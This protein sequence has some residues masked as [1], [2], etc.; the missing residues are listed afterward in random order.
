MKQSRWIWYP[1]DFE[2]YHSLRLHCRREERG[3]CWPAFWHLDD[4]N[5]NV[6]FRKKAVLD[7]NETVTV[8]GH[9]MGYLQADGKKHPYNTPVELVPGE[10]TLEVAAAKP[11]GL[12]AVFIK[13]DVF[14]GTEGWE[15]DDMTGNWLPAGYNDMYPLPED[16][17]E[18][19][20][21]SYEEVGPVS[22][23]RKN[24]GVLF[25]FGRE[26]FA[27]LRFRNASFSEPVP[28]FY[29]ESEAEAL[30]TEWS[31]IRD[32]IPAGMDSCKMKSRAFRYIFV[33]GTKDELEISADYEYLPL[34]PRGNFRSSDEKL[35]RIW[36]T[37]AY[38]F[39]LNC[40]EFF[41]DGIKRDRWVWSGDA[42]QSFL[43]NDYLFFDPGITKRT[44]IA[45][46]GKDPVRQHINTILD[47]SFYW[48]L[49][50]HNYYYKTGDLEFLRFIWPK[51]VTLMDFCLSRRDAEGFVTGM[52]GD[53]VFIDWAEIDKTGA[54]AA[55]QILFYKSLQTMAVCA[56]VLGSNGLQYQNIA[57]ELYQK[58]NRFFWNPRLHA[59]IDSFTSGKNNITRHA[60]IFSILF[61]LVDD[62]RRGEIIR[63][64]LQNDTIPQIATPYF[65]FYELEAFCAAGETVRVH[66]EIL[67]YWGGML[68]LGAATFW[69]E[70]YPN[71][72]FPEH[73]AMYGDK[74]GK[75]LCH[76]WGSSPVYL[77]GRYF[78]G[79]YPDAGAYKHFICA[80]DLADLEWMEGTV[81]GPGG[82]IKVYMDREKIKLYSP[83]VPGT[84]VLKDKRI[85]VFP[86][87]P[88][89]VK[90]GD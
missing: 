75:S 26:L 33:P 74:Y 84:L 1:G 61:N 64:V 22:W 5:Y 46:R 30:D 87:K 49:G 59:Y 57:G 82:E 16:N 31:Y 62:K 83:Q 85:E 18:E 70:Y 37:A 47:Y 63:D 20:R 58:I 60:N 71:M 90:I 35:N 23:K 42:Y 52:P 89:E 72:N 73:Y 17:P 51:M 21:F 8:I 41:L 40:R 55:E 53:W 45:L 79:V 34:E 12:P 19:F 76:A 44:I 50:I 38:T 32:K 69:E 6:K 4:C 67:S 78:L 48:I 2:L 28:V 80:P 81:P 43:I 10:H 86:G 25:D 56:E 29:G 15:V 27:K 11:G 88:I 65:K 7:K 77:L 24:N 36:Q 3:F 54:V 9:G 13:G 68:D 14:S 66:K 39:H